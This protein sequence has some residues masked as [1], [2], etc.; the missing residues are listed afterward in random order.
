MAAELTGPSAGGTPIERQTQVLRDGSGSSVRVCMFVYNNCAAD[1]RVLKEAATLTRAGYQVQ[2]VA[3][4]DKRTVPEEVRDGVRI[5]RIDRNPPHYKLLRRS[6]RVRR[7]LRLRRARVRR[8][9]REA[10]KRGTRRIR[11]RRVAPPV[12]VPSPTPIGQLGAAQASG[13]L[14]PGR[15]YRALRWRVLRT[16]PLLRRTYYR[17]RRG[18]VSRRDLIAYQQRSA[19]MRQKREARLSSLG[20]RVPLPAERRPVIEQRAMETS[21]VGQPPAA[22]EPAPSVAVIAPD[23]GTTLSPGTAGLQGFWRGVD[24]RVSAGAYRVVMLFH[25]PLLY[26]DFYWRTYRLIGETEFDVLHAHDLNTLPVAAA[27]ARRRGMRLI[28]DAHELYPE[29]S[30]LA[31]VERRVWGLVEGPLTRRADCVLT[32]CESIAEELSAR[33]GVPKPAVLLNCPPHVELADGPNL[34][35]EKAGLDGS[36]EPIVLYQGGFAPHRGLPELVEAAGYLSR[37][38]VVLMGWGTLEASLRELVDEL[39]LGHRV[40]MVG[41]AKQSE[42]LSYT[43]GA[44]IG[45]IPYLPV[46]LNNYYTTPNKLFE[47]I[48]AGIPIVGSHV[49]ELRRF[50]E[51][52][53]LGLTFEPGSAQDLGHAL[54]YLLEN[55]DAITSMRRN[56]VRASRQLD[57]QSQEGTLLDIYAGNRS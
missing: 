56:A 33:H 2:I 40:R 49:P 32:V 52:Y 17:R 54:N 46:G 3:V 47:Y 25:K 4:L 6:R 19:T 44:D 9:G 28:Y 23:A 55:N 38:I 37:G 21:H 35:R 1:A 34:L 26:L 27:L 5:V 7:W 15:L 8:L 22:T 18:G 14:R 31:P 57:W 39:E 12:R 43:R 50:L 11:R 45:V 51:G 30:T 42:L 24:K 10:I 20:D 29:V 53:E 48:A 16:V 41:P 36:L 13:S